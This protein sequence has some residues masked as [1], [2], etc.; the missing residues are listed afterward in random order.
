MKINVWMRLLGYIGA[1]AGSTGWLICFVVFYFFVDEA[2]PMWNSLWSLVATVG[3]AVGFV[4]VVEWTASQVGVD[5]WLYHASVIGMLLFDI[6]VLAILLK[7]WLA[8]IIYGY[9]VGAAAR[10]SNTYFLFLFSLGMMLLTVVLVR[11][12][13]AGKKGRV[14]ED[15][16]KISPDYRQFRNKK[17]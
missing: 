13:G 4:I 1:V 8:P 3:L 11:I 7:N 16:F 14:D 10:L 9:S 5:H 17:E 12:R 15:S 2:L 6:G